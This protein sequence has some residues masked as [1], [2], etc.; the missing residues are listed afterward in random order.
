MVAPQPAGRAGNFLARCLSGEITDTMIG[1][2]PVVGV[3]IGHWPIA[4]YSVMGTVRSKSHEGGD[5][6]KLAPG[7]WEGKKK[8]DQRSDR[9]EESPS[10]AGH[11]K[12]VAR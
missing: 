10:G 9:W 4:A 11:P 12:G 3:L 7:S 5:P 1:A 8:W 2:L 6:G